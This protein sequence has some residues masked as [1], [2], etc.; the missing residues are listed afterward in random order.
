M[1]HQIS[2]FLVRLLVMAG[3]SAVA[4]SPAMAQETSFRTY[5]D[6][7]GFTCEF[8]SDWSFDQ[9]Q[10][11]DRIFT[12]PPETARD[13]TIIIQVIDRAV[14]AEPTAIAQL[15]A[16]K[17]Q[18][19]AA[20][21]GKILSEGAAPIAEQQAPYLIASYTVP[22]SSGNQRQFRHIQMAVTAP[23]TFLLMSYSAP[24]ET[25]DQN[26]RVFQNCS[27][28]LKLGV[29]VTPVPPAP[30]VAQVPPTQPT[31]PAP[32]AAQAPDSQ[33]QVTADPGGEGTMIW[34]HNA[35]RGFWITVPSIW[36]QTIDPS[37]PYSVDMQ[38]PERVE[39]V[40]VFVVDMESTST[41]KEYADAWEQHV[42]DKIFFMNDRLAVPE[43]AHPGV[44]VKDVAGIMRRYQ[45]QVNGATV[46]SLA[47]YVVNTKRGFTVVGYH[48]LGDHDGER[49]T[50]Q[51]V[52]SFR[53]T[54]P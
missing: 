29:A 35:D 11:N 20:P 32:P 52:E 50:R 24:D 2:Q 18:L 36:S 37:E 1:L 8:P 31:P 19:L 40:I 46:Q 17:T 54:P 25:F 15:E 53:L 14:T 39:G 16:L 41:V 6:N 3:V 9:A 49:R 47:A 21:G 23:R 44:G 34:R 48:F 4:A 13:A 10:N 33:Q 45:G 12:G 43:T 27:A 42:A 38:H 26:M 51:A 5:Q 22:D 28:T 30:P 7:S